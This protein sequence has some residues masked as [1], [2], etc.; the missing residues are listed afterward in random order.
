MPDIAAIF[1][2]S[3]DPRNGWLVLLAIAVGTWF[4]GMVLAHV[5]RRMATAASAKH[6][7]WRGALLNAATLPLQLLV[8]LAGLSAMATL[9]TAS[10]APRAA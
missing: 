7:L 10:V 4:A 9:A 8:G 5:L 2:S 1:R 3:P 6:A